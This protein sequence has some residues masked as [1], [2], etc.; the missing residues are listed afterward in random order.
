MV[1]LEEEMLQM[2]GG[3]ILQG[4]TALSVVWDGSACEHS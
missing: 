4:E 2:T 3:E 1:G